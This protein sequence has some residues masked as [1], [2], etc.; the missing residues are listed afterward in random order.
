VSKFLRIETVG[1][2]TLPYHGC[3]ECAISVLVTNSQSLTVT[4]PVFVVPDTTYNNNVPLLLGTNVLYHLCDISEEPTPRP[5]K[6]AVQALKLQAR[7]L[8]KSQGVY[9]NVISTS[10][11]SIPP[12]SGQVTEGR[13]TIVIPVCQQIALVQQ[14]SDAISVVPSLVNIKQGSNCVPIDIVNETNFVIHIKRGEH[15]ANLHQ[16]SIH[17]EPKSSDE[18]EFLDSFDFSHLDETET[19]ELKHFLSEHRDVFAMNAKEM[20]CTDILEHR[21]ELEDTTPF[22][23]RERPVPPGMYVAFAHS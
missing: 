2:Q 22:K 20:G 23:E 10:D 4:V 19:T 11:I 12:F 18:T 8:A 14:C 9:S 13:A 17:V 15:L 21:I 1:G 6:L 5:L 3:F 16:A 7:H